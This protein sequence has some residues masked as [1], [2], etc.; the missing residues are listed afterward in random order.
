[1]ILVNENVSEY[2]RS[3]QLIQSLRVVNNL[4]ESYVALTHEFNSSLKS[5]EEQKQYLLQV[6]EDDRKQFSTSTN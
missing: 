6:I 4:A 3:Q 1:M 2:K 5:D